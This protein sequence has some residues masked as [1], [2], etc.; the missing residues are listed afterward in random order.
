M[1]SHRARTFALLL[2]LATA[3][4]PVAARAE[5]GGPGTDTKSG[6]WMFNLKL[7][8]SAGAYAVG[9][10]A[11][12][13][14]P[15]MGI[16]VT[17]DR[18][19]YITFTLG[20]LFNPYYTAIEVAPG[21]EYDIGLPVRG[22]FLYPKISL[23]YTGFIYYA[24]ALAATAQYVTHAFLVEPAFGVKYVIANRWQVGAEPVCLPLWF[25]GTPG[26]TVNGQTLSATTFIGV[27][28]Q[29]LVWGGVNF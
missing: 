2:G 22:L 24:N 25:G 9:T 29:I 10:A 27:A 12:A 4:L 13:F 7:G 5:A 15:E 23:G 3:A 1:C 16:A 26:V 18:H 21:F 17:S 28:Y 20:L 11:F 6:P 19:G 8:V 14:K